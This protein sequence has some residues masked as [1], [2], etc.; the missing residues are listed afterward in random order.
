MNPKLIAAI[1]AATQSQRVMFLDNLRALCVRERQ[2]GPADK[3]M[4]SDLDLITT[5][6][7]QQMTAARLAGII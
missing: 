6:A 5:T 4:V 7:E 3:P 2:T 1:K